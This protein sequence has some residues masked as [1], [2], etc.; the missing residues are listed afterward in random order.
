MLV[1]YILI[2]EPELTPMEAIKKSCAMMKGHKLQTF[3]FDLSYIGWMILS[4]ITF[5]IV[6]VFYVEPYR[7]CARA[8]IYIELRKNNN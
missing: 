6:G 4:L 3:M 8:A 2:D 5:R 7:R 1:P